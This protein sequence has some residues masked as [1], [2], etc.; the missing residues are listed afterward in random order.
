MKRSDMRNIIIEEIE[1]I[2]KNIEWVATKLANSEL[3]FAKQLLAKQVIKSL[4]N[5]KE[6]LEKDEDS[7]KTNEL[8]SYK[9]PAL[10]IKMNELNES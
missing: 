10:Y 1:T 8:I 7:Y 4:T 6:F 9:L 5:V 3:T 2:N